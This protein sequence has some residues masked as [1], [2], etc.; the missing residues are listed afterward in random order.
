[1]AVGLVSCGRFYQPSS[2]QYQKVQVTAEAPRD[3]ALLTLLKPYS[4]SV[5]L[6]MN[7]VIGELSQTLDKK[8]PE[9]TLG[10]LMTDAV[11]AEAERIYGTRVD[12]AF[13]NYGGIRLMQLP[14]GPLTTGKVYELMPFD[15][16]L[17]LQELPGAVLQQFLDNVA[18]RG[19]WPVSGLTYTIQNKKAVDVR[20][21]GQSLDP[22]KTYM[23]ANSDYVANGGDDSNMLK[24]IPQN[25]KGYLVRDALLQYFSAYAKR[26]EKITAP[27]ENRIRYAD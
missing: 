1:M 27:T 12:A 11:K 19:G 16:L 18:A 20:I 15:N 23:V 24:T 9:T 10:N 4:D 25:N 8:L 26:G 21:G 22:A 13:I 17:I 3:A 5:N 7:T 6:N 14:A 2:L